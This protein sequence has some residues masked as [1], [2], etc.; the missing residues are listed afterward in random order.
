MSANN[1]SVCPRCAAVSLKHREAKLQR[2]AD[3]YGKVGLTKF[4]SM[5]SEAAENPAEKLDE[6]MR[7]D[8]ELGLDEQGN[9]YVS[10]RAHCQ[11]CG[12]DYRFKHEEKVSLK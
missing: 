1:W 5:Q 4:V 10:Y 12:F 9:F 6:T 11:Q 3:A 8:W 7:E 2:I